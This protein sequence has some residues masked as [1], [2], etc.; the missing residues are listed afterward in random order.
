MVP[1]TASGKTP[2]EDTISSPTLMLTGHGTGYE[3]NL[4]FVIYSLVLICCC[5]ILIILLC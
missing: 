5:S 4:S 2:V 1:I 3:L